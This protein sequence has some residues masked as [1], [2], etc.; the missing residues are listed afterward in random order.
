MHSNLLTC[1]VFILAGSSAA[2]QLIQPPTAE[3][4]VIVVTGTRGGDRALSVDFEKVARGCAECK[5]ILAKMGDLKSQYTI[6]KDQIARDR[7]AM[8]GSIA[9]HT[10]GSENRRGPKAPDGADFLNPNSLEPE[11]SQSRRL[12]AKVPDHFR[13][14]Q[15][16]LALVRSNV[17]GQIA[18]YL[19]QLEPYVVEAAEAER[20][21]RNA[22]VV[23]KANRRAKKEKA[24]DV[25]QAVISRLNARQISITLPPSSLPE[26]IQKQ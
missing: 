3:E 15:N 24:V 22:S 9:A 4:G 16:D 23:L 11:L 25:T 12:V 10:S 6:K 20:L 7:S 14:D 18:S 19:A 2:A 26:K 1:A 8:A 21:K 5:R 13:K 17:S